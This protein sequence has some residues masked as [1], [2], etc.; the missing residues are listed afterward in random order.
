M[1]MYDDHDDGAT[2][3]IEFD[4]PRGPASKARCTSSSG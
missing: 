4:D 2:E 1:Q 3:R